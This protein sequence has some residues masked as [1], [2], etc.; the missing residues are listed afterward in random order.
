MSE[1]VGAELERKR[2]DTAPDVV[3][4]TVADGIAGFSY[5]MTVNTKRNPSTTVGEELV[6]IDGVITASDAEGG[7]VEFPWTAGDADQAPGL[8]WYDIE[9]TDAA[10]KIKTIAKN[11]YKFWQDISK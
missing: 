8:Y 7:T 6:T 9:Q 11:K 1:L 2:G 4:V 5:R 10:G 3:N